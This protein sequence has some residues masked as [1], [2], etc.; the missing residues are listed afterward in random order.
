MIVAEIL[1]NED[2]ESFEVFMQDTYKVIR[3]YKWKI[4][5]TF[6]VAAFLI[7]AMTFLIGFDEVITTLK[8][9]KSE[10]IIFNF[11]IEAIITLVWTARWKMILDVVDT[12]LL[13]TSSY[14]SK[15]LPFRE[16]VKLDRLYQ[17][18]LGNLIF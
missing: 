1:F 11:I 12:C 16:N 14:F 15:S 13:Y 10:W 17:D 18:S 9:A 2:L 5:T 6:A 4:L 7:F 8:K 3:K